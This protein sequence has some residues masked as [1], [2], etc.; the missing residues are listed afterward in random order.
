METWKGEGA[1]DGGKREE[2]WCDSE[3]VLEVRA[4]GAREWLLR[5]TGPLGSRKESGFDP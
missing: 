4:A 5:R 3:A 1:G 2:D